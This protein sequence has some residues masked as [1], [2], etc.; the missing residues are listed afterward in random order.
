M[1]GMAVCSIDVFVLVAKKIIIQV[2]YVL[3]ALLNVQ[4]VFLYDWL[5]RHELNISASHIEDCND[6]DSAQEYGFR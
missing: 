1:C 2:N 6:I 5:T 3:A 4:L